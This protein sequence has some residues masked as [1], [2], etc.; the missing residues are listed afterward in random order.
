MEN[1]AKP[2][3]VVANLRALAHDL[4][5]SL[6]T[7]LQAAYLLQE[8]KLDGKNKKWAQAIDTA[9]RDAARINREIRKILNS[10]ASASSLAIGFGR[11]PDLSASAFANDQRPRTDDGFYPSSFAVIVIFALS[12][13]ETGH[14]LLA[15]SAAF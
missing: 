10:R 6:E 7:V 12:T 4:S 3:D 2:A 9:A 15:F 14:P 11:W 13:L 1:A 5:N 8:A